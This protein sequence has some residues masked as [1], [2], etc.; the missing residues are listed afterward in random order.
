MARNKTLLYI[1]CFIFLNVSLTVKLTALEQSPFIWR[2]WDTSDGLAENY[3]GS[4]TLGENGKI[5]V[6]HGDRYTISV[7][8]GY[9]VEHIPIPG[10]SSVNI[11]Q[12]ENN[13]LWSFAGDKYIT[14][15]K[16]L[17]YGLQRYIGGKWE[18]FIVPQ[19]ASVS[20]DIISPFFEEL[21]SRN[22]N[23]LNYINVWRLVP[24]NQEAVLVALPKQVLLFDAAQ[25]KTTE[26][27]N[28]DS[29]TGE[30]NEIILADDCCA[31]VGATQALIKVQWNNDD[32]QNSISTKLYPIDESLGIYSIKHLFAYNSEELYATALTIDDPIQVPIQYKNGSITVLNEIA[33]NEFVGDI[34]KEATGN[35]FALSYTQS[36][37]RIDNLFQTN[38]FG[39]KMKHL[40]VEVTSSLNFKPQIEPNGNLWLNMYTE[41]IARGAKKI[42]RTS[43]YA[44][45]DADNINNILEDSDGRLIFVRYDSF[46]IQNQSNVRYV[47]LPNKWEERG[48]RSTQ[49]ISND[50][51]LI[52]DILGQLWNF[53]LKQKIITEI[54]LPTGY[55]AHRLHEYKFNSVF[56]ILHLKQNK[57]DRSLWIYDGKSFI[58]KMNF[59][60]MSDIGNITAVCYTSNGELWLGGPSG[61][62]MYPNLSNSDFNQAISYEYPFIGVNSIIECRNGSI[63]IGSEEGIAEYDHHKWK[64][65]TED[66]TVNRMLQARDGSIWT[67][68]KNM[69]Y[70]FSMN[71]WVSYSTEEGIDESLI[72]T[73][74]FEDQQGQIIVGTIRGAYYYDPSADQDPPLTAINPEENSKQV[75]PDGTIRFVFS[76]IDKWK[77][78]STDRLLYS[79]R[80]D[81]KDWSSFQENNSVLLRDISYGD[82]IFSVRAMDRNWNIDST[83]ATFNFTV[84]YPWYYQSYFILSISILVFILLYRFVNL[85]YLVHIRTAKMKSEINKRIE[86]EG[87][88]REVSEREQRRIGQ[89]L[90]D[91]LSQLLAGTLLLVRQLQVEMEINNLKQSS[92][93]NSIEYF[94]QKSVSFTQNLIRGLTPISISNCGLE[95]ALKEYVI[96]VNKLFNIPVK[97]NC[98][99]DIAIFNT[100]IKTNIYR[101]IQE[102]VNN[103]VKYSKA[104]HIDISVS[105]FDEHY[106]FLIHDDGIGFDPVK[107]RKKGMG[108][109]IMQYR[110]SLF[111]G[112]VSIESNSNKGTCVSCIVSKKIELSDQEE[113]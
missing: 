18:R 93:A 106:Y 13:V 48:V 38:Q 73:V 52:T 14:D 92:Q 69:V 49:L 105:S 98:H 25:Q 107:P 62:R 12:T 108:L 56:V 53:D 60:V 99:C 66:F 71:S 16:Q 11:Y 97:L 8:D 58:K 33:H 80:I 112:K 113:R 22:I 2:Y 70:Q 51:C 29:Q 74:L 84:L 10:P 90:H 100:G 55:R 31:Y 39:L 82:H 68:N 61:I 9:T 40:P 110:A 50:Q 101:I 37:I 72:T 46:L 104:N 27:L 21:T 96:N 28:A 42:W 57:Y 20:N 88:V 26:L 85:E 34:W 109:Q 24:I 86:L 78:T 23:Y 4:L 5:Y 41:G 43:Q 89:D 35:I 67:I 83:P 103:A 19:I 63:W 7:L 91:G 102:A 3:Y 36:R 6:N 76:G 94:L 47:D 81:G 1:I 111:N 32:I 45:S 65:I 54:S 77:Y 75:A 15:F 95:E 59:G 87:M 44:G 64:V 17:R 30:F 79:Y